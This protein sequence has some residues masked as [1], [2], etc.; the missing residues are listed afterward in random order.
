[1][2]QKITLGILFV[3]LFVFSFWLMFHTFSYDPVHNDMLISAKAWSDFGGYIPQIRSFSNGSNWP[4]QYPLFPG[5]PT[6]YHFL[7]Y[8]IIGLLEKSGLRIDLATN[9]LSGLGLFLLILA[10]WLLAQKIFSDKRVSFLAIVFF[11]F[12]GSFSWL[13]YFK[14]ANYSFTS[15]VSGL[16]TLTQFPSF[17]PWNGSWI[18][19][20]WNLNIYTN[21]R[22]LAL[23][24]ALCIF[25]I[26]ILLSKNRYLPLVAGLLLGSFLVLNQAVFAIAALFCS[27]YFLIRPHIRKTL[28]ISSLGLLPW[29]YFFQFISHAGQTIQFHPGYLIPGELTVFSFLKFWFLNI[30]IHSLL[31][32]VGLFLAPAK[33][34]SLFI[35]LL[36]LFIIPN[37]FQLSPDIINNHKLFN[38]VIIVCQIF[39]AFALVY[40]WDKIHPLRLLL[41]P[42]FFLLI[43]GGVIDF[44]PVKNDYFLKIPDL[45]TNPDANFFAKH[46][47]SNAVV[48]N[49]TWFYHP[50]S[51]AGRSIFN[52][53]S[54]FTWSFGYDQITR[55]HQTISIYAAPT[56]VLACQ[57]LHAYNISYVE[58]S[59]HP[60]NF[61][62][63]N[64]Q[65]W[66]N[67]FTPSYLNSQ[68]GLSVY[69]TSQNCP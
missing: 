31:I 5:V 21:Q 24:Y 26:I 2:L 17:G 29:L 6:R 19:A 4:P 68:T 8:L 58:L 32:P 12:N 61:I 33:S 10:I 43:L 59:P 53:Y 62:R 60:E 34:R 69:S 63:P 27:W 25:L 51:L 11:L 41:P 28:L 57:L 48:L 47:P 15:A 66:R 18:T 36:L 20:F 42:V 30:G 46:T 14:S 49:S 37:V 44:F 55:E 9:I 3:F 39:S 54:Y 56:K 64:W 35:P 52:G 13:D 40:I 38:F 45:P 50:A 23:S 16:S 67:D 65:M 7:F 22:H 1:M